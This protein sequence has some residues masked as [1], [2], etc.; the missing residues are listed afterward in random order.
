MVGKK[1]WVNQGYVKGRGYGHDVYGPAGGRVY[2][3][4]DP[5]GPIRPGFQREFSELK[6][7]KLHAFSTEGKDKMFIL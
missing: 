1:S 5:V 6:L 2:I 4:P 3:D 7:L